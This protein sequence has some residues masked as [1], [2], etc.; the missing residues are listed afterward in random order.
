MDAAEQHMESSVWECKVNGSSWSQTLYNRPKVKFPGIV[1]QEKGGLSLART[2]TQVQQAK[3]VSFL[4]C[5]VPD[6][7]SE[8]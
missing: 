5:V 4:S 2:S 3:R 6:R 8:V 7:E 1:N